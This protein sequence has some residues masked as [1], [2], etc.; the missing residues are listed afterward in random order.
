MT[1]TMQKS[2]NPWLDHVKKYRSEHP[3]MKFKDVLVAAKSTYTKR[4]KI[5]PEPKEHPWMAHLERLKT[6]D[7]DWKSKYSYKEFLKFAKTTYNPTA[8]S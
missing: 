5:K 1:D 6:D 7:P 2:S 3:E 4:V 8:G